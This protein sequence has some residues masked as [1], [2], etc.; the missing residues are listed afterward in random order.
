M[1]TP[2]FSAFVLDRRPA[3]PFFVLTYATV[4]LGIVAV[5]ILW[6]RIYRR[7]WDQAR[8]RKWSIVPGV[9]DEGEIVTMM[10]GR[11]DSIAGYDIYMGYSYQAAGKQEGQ[12]T[13]FF[14]TEEEAIAAKERL[15]N[16]RVIVHVAPGKPTKSRILD[17][18]LSAIL[19]KGTHFVD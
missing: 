10:Q 18:D 11:S 16:Q 17:E 6:D 1:L 12:Y 13:C 4:C 3:T 15:A 5:S 19:P 7:K 8:A 2:G 9:F 14:P